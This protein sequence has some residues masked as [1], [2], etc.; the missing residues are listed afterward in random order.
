LEQA[1]SACDVA[2]LRALATS[3]QQD[4]QL[5]VS[6]HEVDAVSWS[7]VNPQFIDTFAHRAYVTL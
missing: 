2:S 3:A 5:R 4:D 6:P 7:V 1:L